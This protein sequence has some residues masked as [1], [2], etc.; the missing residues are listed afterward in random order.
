MS[1]ELGAAATRQC[2]TLLSRTARPDTR[3]GGPHDG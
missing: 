1:E 3:S 2:A